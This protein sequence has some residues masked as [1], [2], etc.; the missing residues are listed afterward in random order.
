M[1]LPL[2]TCH[3][4]QSSTTQILFEDFGGGHSNLGEEN[5]SSDLNLGCI[6]GPGLDHT[7]AGKETRQLRRHGRGRAQLNEDVI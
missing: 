2:A 1:R 3:L 6:N 7:C 5:I 4:L